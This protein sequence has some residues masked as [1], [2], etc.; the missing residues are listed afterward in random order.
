MN[1]HLKQLLDFH[2]FCHP[3]GNTVTS[4]LHKSVLIQPVSRWTCIVVILKGLFISAIV[5]QTKCCNEYWM[6]LEDDMVGVIIG[7]ASLVA[8]FPL[9]SSTLWGTPQFIEAERRMHICVGK[10]T[11]IASDNGLSPGRRQDIIWTNAG[12]LLIG[13]L[14][15][16][17]NEILIELHTFSF[18][19]M[20]LK[21][22]SAKW[23][24]FCLGLN[25][26]SSFTDVGIG[27]NFLIICGT[28]WYADGGLNSGR[29]K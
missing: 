15:T 18:K 29:K 10:L 25:V 2:K 21:M 23:R 1:N 4:S 13:P 12:I 6:K 7:E 20:Q 24:P 3:L 17:F 27:Q 16:N 19:K 9:R 5:L 14:E 11:N 22:S 28:C 8:G 26:L